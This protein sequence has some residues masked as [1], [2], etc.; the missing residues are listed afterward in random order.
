MKHF[1]IAETALTVSIE[2]YVPDNWYGSRYR[3]VLVPDETLSFAN[4]SDAKKY[5]AKL[6][7]WVNNK[8]IKNNGLKPVKTAD[9]EIKSYRD[10]PTYIYMSMGPSYSCRNINITISELEK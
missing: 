1:N 5:A 4:I 6:S 2:W 10:L 7:K 3:V 9:V 8:Y